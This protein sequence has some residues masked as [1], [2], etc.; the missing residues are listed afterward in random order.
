MLRNKIKRPRRNRTSV[1][2]L[3]NQQATPVVMA[4]S[5]HPLVTLV[6]IVAN[7]P[8][9]HFRSGKA[10]EVALGVIVVLEVKPFELSGSTTSNEL[11]LSIGGI[12]GLRLA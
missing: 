8:M 7:V 9:Y 12:Q 2:G 10:S 11:S 1:G 6:D 5:G 3:A 4:A